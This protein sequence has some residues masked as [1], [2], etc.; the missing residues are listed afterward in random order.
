MNKSPLLLV[1]LTLLFFSKLEKASY[2]YEMLRICRTE[3]LSR[4]EWVLDGGLPPPRTN[5]RTLDKGALETL[6]F[7]SND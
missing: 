3:V 6:S 5:T 4:S 7:E 2:K 1:I